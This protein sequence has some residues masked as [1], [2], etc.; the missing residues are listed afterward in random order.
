MTHDYFNGGSFIRSAVYDLP[1]GESMVRY[2]PWCT[3]VFR[4]HIR[5]VPYCLGVF[6]HQ[7]WFTIRNDDETITER[8]RSRLRFLWDNK[9]DE[10]DITTN[11]EQ[12]KF[13]A[14]NT[15]HRWLSNCW[16]SALGDIEGVWLKADLG[17][18]KSI[19]ALVIANHWFNPGSTVT[20][21][22][23]N[24][25]AWGA[26]ALEQELEI[27]DDKTIIEHFWNTAKSYR[28]WRLHMTTSMVSGDL[29]GEEDI[30][31]RGNRD[32]VPYCKPHFKI[33]RIFLGDYFE[34]SQNFKERK[35]EY[36]EESQEYRTDR[37]G[38]ITE[39]P[40]W[41]QREFFY[42]FDKLGSGDYETIWDIYEVKGK[43][44]PFFIIEDYKYWWKRT[45]YV[46]FKD[47]L[48]YEYLYGRVNT[49]L[50]LKETR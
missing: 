9:W 39:R 27:F 32:C 44:I 25:D 35:P 5:Y 38:H 46:T 17:E 41:K 18:A 19:R 34:V 37:E 16:R 50:H 28:Y 42:K 7:M 1:R 30:S 43:G 6:R 40:A 3:G 23:N 49:E 47:V 12:A 8:E 48:E 21:Q 14:S 31:T 22:A 4:K 13:P 10:A 24:A 45:F 15:Q 33:G 20:I 26:P 36:E 11:S 29:T 2:V